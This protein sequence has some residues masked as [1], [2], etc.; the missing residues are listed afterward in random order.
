MHLPAYFTFHIH[1]EHILGITNVAAD[2]LSR[3]NL[4]LFSSLVPQT[5][6]VIVPQSVS[7]LLVTQMPNWGIPTWTELFRNVLVKVSHNQH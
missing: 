2:T 4:P 7:G 1:S 5:P 3:D 6:Q